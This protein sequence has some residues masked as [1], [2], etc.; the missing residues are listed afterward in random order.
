MH[1]IN[2][3]RDRGRAARWKPKKWALGG[4]ANLFCSAAL[5]RERIKG[6]SNADEIRQSDKIRYIDGI[7]LTDQVRYRS[8]GEPAAERSAQG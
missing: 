8:R 7:R 1:P 6:E 4:D 5:S 2:Q 3:Q